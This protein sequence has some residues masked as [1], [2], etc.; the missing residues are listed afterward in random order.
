MIPGMGG[1]TGGISGG[2]GG[3]PISAGGGAAGDSTAT[4]TSHFGGIKQ[5]AINMGGGGIAAQ[6]PMIAM[7]CV[8]LFVMVKK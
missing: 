8:V 2:A 5:G 4:S 3:M 6:L 7:A 1:L